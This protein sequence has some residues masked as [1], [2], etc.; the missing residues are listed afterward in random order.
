M[1]M[2]GQDGL[3][4][5][6]GAW[7]AFGCILVT[8]LGVVSLVSHSAQPDS[9]YGGHPPAWRRL[10]WAVFAVTAGVILLGGI[11]LLSGGAV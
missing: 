6:F 11:R 7:T 9:S 1:R 5:A 2:L 8:I 4:L 3:G 10:Q